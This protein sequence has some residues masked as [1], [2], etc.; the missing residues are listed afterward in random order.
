MRLLKD[1]T[2]LVIVDIQEKLFPH[3]HENEKLINNCKKLI[4]GFKALNVPII[5]TEQYTKGLGVTLKEIQDVLEENYKPIEK[6]DFSC[7]GSSQF[8]DELHNSKKKNIILIGIE[9]HVC[10]LQTALDLLNEGF[11]PVLIEDCV[12]SRKLNDKNIA[13]QRMLH[14]GCIVST[15]ESILFELCRKAGNETFKAISKIVK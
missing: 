12:S 3:I 14:E 7:C 5:I 10:V 15:L 11:Q 6:I 9:T 2:I 13:V 8:L 4:E 1:D